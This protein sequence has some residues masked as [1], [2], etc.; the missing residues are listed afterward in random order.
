V[1]KVGVFVNESFS[2][3]M[4]KVKNC[5]LT[6]IQLHGA[7]S[8]ELV[9][10][11][12]NKNLNVI[13]VLF[14]E[15]KPYIEDAKLYNASAY[16]IEHGKGKLPG[17]NAVEWNWTL[18]KEFGNQFPLILAGGLSPTNISYA[19]SISEPDAVD[20]CSG[21]ESKPGKKDFEKVK[22]FTNSILKANISKQL[23][24]IF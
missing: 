17:G 24:N 21:V 22:L 2:F 4:S 5:N 7:E 1:Q 23:R 12:R 13:K 8:P 18:V 9:L 20:T 10:R 3:I 14:I 6:Y 11:L 15:K 16:L 19:I